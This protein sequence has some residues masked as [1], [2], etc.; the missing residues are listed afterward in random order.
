MSKKVFF[1][2][3]DG[4]INADRGYVYRRAEW[5]WQTGVFE[6][7]KKLQ[8][9]GFELAIITNQSGIGEG[10]YTIDDMERLHAWMLEE[11][12]K[13]G[14]TVAAIGYCP[15][16][17]QDNCSC[18]KPKRGMIDQVAERIGEID[19]AQSWVIGDKPLDLELGKNI[20]AKTA[21]VRSKYWKEEELTH[22]P[23]LIIDSLLEAAR[24]I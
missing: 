11:L 6:A 17:A 14:I 20:G 12:K 16:T 5:Q 23:D 7:L 13:D 3:R 4:V 24:Q 1:L 22:K 21:L 2:D 8:E 9:A 10:Y 15:H 18:R 19:F